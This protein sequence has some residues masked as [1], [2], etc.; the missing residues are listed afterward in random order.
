MSSQTFSE[1]MIISYV[2][3]VYGACCVFVTKSRRTL[4]V[5]GAKFEFWWGWCAGVCP[6]S[7]F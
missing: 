1:R 3:F 4:Q 6:G 7:D 2:L 5:A